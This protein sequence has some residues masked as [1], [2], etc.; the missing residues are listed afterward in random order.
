[1]KNMSKPLWSM[2]YWVICLAFLLSCTSAESDIYPYINGFKDYMYFQHQVDIS[3]TSDSKYVVI[4]INGCEPCV[5]N[6]LEI[7]CFM[8]SKENIIPILVGVAQQKD[9][10]TLKK[11]V[12]SKYSRIIY[13]SEAMIAGYSTGYGYPIM[14]HI[15]NG[16]VVK[17]I[18]ITGQ[19]TEEFREYLEQ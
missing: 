18:D 16:K 7:L 15:K 13:D 11:K 2:R 4:G 17:Y 14:V 9:I 6:M 1:M 19:S 10:R 12:E 3:N 8:N 5:L